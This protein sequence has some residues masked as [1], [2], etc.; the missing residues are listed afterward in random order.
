[1]APAYRRCGSSLL[2]AGAIL[3][4]AGP[5]ADLDPARGLSARA[6]SLLELNGADGNLGL[7]TSIDGGV[8][9]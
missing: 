8:D 3:V 4:A 9:S 7:H 6:E 1:M 2:I 5:G